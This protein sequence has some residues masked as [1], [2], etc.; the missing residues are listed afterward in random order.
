MKNPYDILGVQK[1]ASHDEIKKAYRKLAKELHPDLHPDDKKIAERFKEASAAYSLLSNAE[2][3]AKFDRG[4][5]GADGGAQGNA[6][7]QEAY[8]QY[9]RANAGARTSSSAHFDFNAEDFFSDIFSGNR[10]K[11]GAAPERGSDRIYQVTIDFLD[12]VKGV[13][14]RITLENGKTLDIKIPVNVRE[15]QQIRLKGQGGKGVAGGGDGDALVEVNIAPHAFF[16]LD[17]NDIHMDLPITL[18]EA[19]MG[20]K[21]QVPTIDGPVTLNIPAGSNSGKKLRLKGKGTLS[22]KS[23]TR[24]D[25]YVTLQVMLPEPVDSELQKAIETWSKTHSYRARDKLE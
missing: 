5:I 15:G 13:K 22:G 11:R 18:P 12:A 9:Q 6:G 24:G 7:F 23:S 2:S 17:G 1:S 20:G 25:Q 21:V 16:T 8:R 10:R 3:R 19:V 4:E 14:R